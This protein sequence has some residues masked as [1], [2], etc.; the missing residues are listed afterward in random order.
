METTAQ[1]T[2][3][4]R[5]CGPPDSANGGYAC[6]IL[7][8]RLPGPAEVTLHR[9]PPLDTP[10]QVRQAGDGLELMHGAELVATAVTTTIDLALPES[11]A[12]ELAV[13]ASKGYPGFAAHPFRTCFVCGPDREAG[14]GLRIFAGPLPGR[15]VAAA[16][17]VPSNDVCDGDGRV[18]PACL[19]AALDCPS[20][21]GI[22]AH[23]GQLPM[24]LLGRLAVHIERR[25]RSAERC[26]AVG[27][28]REMKGRKLH[29]ASALLG[30]A[31]DWVAWSRSTWIVLK[32]G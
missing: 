15:P 24:A 28:V 6:G 31:G 26:V 9:P 1:L 20:Y 18:A 13:E 8:T 16:P 17:W 11:V 29:T 19:W 27:W 2:I 4:R 22:H 10:L 12:F 25:P 7:G 21:F 5:F 23:T 30:E 14:D 3:A 32:T